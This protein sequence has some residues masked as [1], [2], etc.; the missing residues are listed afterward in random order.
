VGLRT[1]INDVER[2][3]ILPQQD[4]NSDLSVIQPVASRYTDCAIHVDK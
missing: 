2:R 4:S 1:G 3:K